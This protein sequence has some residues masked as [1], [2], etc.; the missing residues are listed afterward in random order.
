MTCV[1][2][3]T[4]AALRY[5]GE[6]QTTEKSGKFDIV[7]LEGAVSVNGSHLHIAIADSH[8]QMTGGHLQY[9]SLV[10]TTAEVVIIELSGLEFLRSH[11]ASTGYRE[12]VVRNNLLE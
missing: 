4:H 1:G 2:S 6:E 7:S 9:G 12:L 3:L 5:A 8:G 10:Y 11:D